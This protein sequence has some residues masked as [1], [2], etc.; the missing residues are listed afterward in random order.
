MQTKGKITSIRFSI[1]V[2][3][4]LSNASKGVRGRVA[5]IVSLFVIEGIQGM[6]AK[7]QKRRVKECT[8]KS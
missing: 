3:Q 4:W 6:E 2:D 8:K 7:Q 1:E 5:E